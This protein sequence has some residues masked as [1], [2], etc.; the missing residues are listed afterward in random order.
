M[1]DMI[2]KRKEHQKEKGE[3]NMT[4][5]ERVIATLEHKEVDRFPR[6]YWILSNTPRFN[7]E[8]L[9]EFHNIFP[10]D[11]CG[12]EIFYG[13]SHYSKGIPYTI[14]KYTDEFG[15]EW[16]VTEEGTTGEVKNAIF[17]DW[18]EFEKYRMPYEILDNIDISKVNESC[19]NS[20]QFILCSTH[21]RPFERMQFMRG[22][23][24]LF[25]DLAS[26]EKEV[27]H[28][29]KMLHSFY[30]KELELICNTDI[31][32]VFFMDDWGTQLSLLISPK[33]W[34]EFFKPMYRDYC[35]LAHSKG[36][37]VF[38]HSDGNI[39]E[40]YPDLIEIGINAINSQLFC[41][42]IEKVISLYGDKITFWGEIDRQNIIP[43]GTIQDVKNAVDR[44]SNAIISK[45]KKRTG[46]IAQCTWT[47]FDPYDNIKA[48]FERWNE[49]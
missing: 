35:N 12:A 15:C 14:G 1:E 39:E 49:K 5:R 6:H 22:T 48:V 3:S 32:G 34:R 38:F 4:S 47:A 27:I 42:D 30:L 11:I 37:Y 17:E 36:K 28:L 29:A 19:K 24:N 16:E 2:A 13:R 23:E 46:S 20:E 21:I 9:K 44:V 41:M 8:L 31:D 26:G 33:L 10:S 45:N 43:F 25:M 18:S 7:K 40:I